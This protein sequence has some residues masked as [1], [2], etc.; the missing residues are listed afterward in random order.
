MAANA[1]PVT[2]PAG[3]V[4]AAT[5]VPAFVIPPGHQAIAMAVPFVNGLAGYAKAGDHVNVYGAF[6]NAPANDKLDR[7]AAK[8]VMSDIEVLWVSNADPAT[9]TYMLSV[10][11]SQA[12]QIVYLQSFE[13]SYLT[14]A[15]DGQGQLTTVGRNPRNAA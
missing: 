6:K 8:L 10:D 5:G 2:Q 4:A 11:A 7:T 12:E 13:A 3:T 15:R 1:T 9:T 14:L